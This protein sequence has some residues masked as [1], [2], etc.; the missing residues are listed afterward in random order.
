M[1]YTE[2]MTL[3]V[4]T[5]QDTSPLYPKV[6]WNRPVARRGAGRLLVPGGHSGELHAPVALHDL[7]LAAG[8]GECVVA[9]PDTLARMLG[10]APSSVFVPSNPSG[11]I[12]RE[13][14]GRLLHLAEDADALMLGAALSGHSETTT[15]MERLM[16]ESSAPV[17]AFD[18]AMRTLLLNPRL[19]CER[20][21]A[22][23][24]LTMPEVFRLSGVLRLPIAIRTGGGLMNKLEIVQ[25]LARAIKPQV[26]VIGSETIVADDTRLIVT[27][28]ALR[29]ARVPVLYYATL[30]TFWVQNPAARLEGLATGA[31]VVKLV[32]DIL[33]PDD[34]LT[35]AVLEKALTRAVE[36]D[37]F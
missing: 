27:P 10:G 33:S 28:A 21:D 34:A 36:P 37:D 22:L 12:G 31:W 1:S 23:L 24:I 9:L 29:L 5:R 3:P 6:L 2:G 7:A 26:A 17:I 32:G 14:L 30:A 4:F 13:A 18:E 25:A 11:S 16:L 35:A 15:L 8:A 19:L 20:E